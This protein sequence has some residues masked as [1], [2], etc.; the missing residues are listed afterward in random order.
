MLHPGVL[1]LHNRITYVHQQHV[2]LKYGKSLHRHRNGEMPNV[3]LFC[4]MVGNVM[5]AAS[6]HE[7]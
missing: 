1:L 7:R 3:Q 6:I 2:Q 5:H 4:A